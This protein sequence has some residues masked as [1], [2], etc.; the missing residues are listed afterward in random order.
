MEL[1]KIIA[2]HN[3]VETERLR[4]AAAFISTASDIKTLELEGDHDNAGSIQIL[5]ALRTKLDLIPIKQRQ[6][7]EQAK[8]L[9]NE[10]GPAMRGIENQI[11][12]IAGAIRTAAKDKLRADIARN[13]HSEAA[14]GLDIIVEDLARRGNG[15]QAARVLEGS[16]DSS[17]EAMRNGKLDVA[18]EI[19]LSALEDGTSQT[20]ALGMKEPSKAAA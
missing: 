9:R 19:L 2:E 16:I 3:R 11:R 5:M 4:L 1:K 10:A 6:I 12:K 20:V 18:C 13:L 15:E 14:G 8:A 17:H 7:D